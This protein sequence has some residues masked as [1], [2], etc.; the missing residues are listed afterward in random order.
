L[1]W[2]LRDIDLLSTLL[3]AANLSFEALLLG[4]IAFFYWRLRVLPEP[5]PRSSPF[6]FAVFAGPP[7]LSQV[8]ELVSVIL[9]SA[10]LLGDSDLH[11]RD[12][13]T[14]RFF[15][16]GVCA[17]VVALLFW[18]C[19]RVKTRKA[20]AAMIPLSLLL[21]IATV[22]TSHAEA[23]MDHRF[24]LALATAAHHLGTAAWIGAMP[25]LLV[26]LGRCRKRAAS[27]LYGQALLVDGYPERRGPG[28]G[29]DLHGLVLRGHL[30]W[31]L[32]NQ[33][34]RPVAGQDLPVCW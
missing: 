19:A 26:S 15:V 34:R 33:L 20:V 29:R 13:I 5:L 7:S 2:L 11:F 18:I 17:A 12:V 21:L 9:S 25:F 31:A 3:R 1:I 27:P 28:S 10:S 30:E 8:T 16:A 14:T 4:G 6:A 24:S 23:R 32:W 22:A